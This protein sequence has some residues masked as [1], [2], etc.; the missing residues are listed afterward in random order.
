MRQA[1]KEAEDKPA[2]RDD[3]KQYNLNE[4]LD[5][6]LSP[7]VEMSIYDLGDDPVDLAEME[8]L[9]CWL[10][11]DLS[12]SGDLTV[13]VACWRDGDTYYLWAWFFCPK[14]NLSRRQEQSGRPYLD[15]AKGG[16]IEATP[17]NVVDLRAV[18]QTIRDI[19]E[20][21]DVR[22]IA[23]DPALAPWR[24]SQSPRGWF[25]RGERAARGCHH[26]A[27]DRCP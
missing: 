10:G 23:F 26:D 9:P 22:E 20:R 27:A 25:P 17:G 24:S 6:S 15:W 1:A 14:D 12:S 7:F 13:I 8:G 19:C 11:V 3:F 2:D 16:L 4:W 18:E 5:H 21:F